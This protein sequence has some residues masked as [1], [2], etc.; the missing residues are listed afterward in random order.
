VANDYSSHSFCHLLLKKYSI[1]LKEMLQGI[2][3]NPN[4]EIEIE[5]LLDL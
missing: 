2:K 1:I 4:E 3:N 5:K